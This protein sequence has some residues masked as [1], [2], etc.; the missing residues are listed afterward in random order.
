MQFKKPVLLISIALI[1]S[2]TFLVYANSLNGKFIWDDEYLIEKNTHIRNW[3][4]L[5]KI[6]TEPTGLSADNETHYYRP[7]QILSYLIDYSFWGLNAKGYHFG[8]ILF[9]TLVALAIFWL[10]NI[11]YRDWL[12]ALLTSLSLQRILSKP[13]RSVI[14]LAEL[15]P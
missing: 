15:T 2:L 6:F 14:S 12:L 1:I 5:V 7:V 8:N 13:K 4:G 9:H 3:S 10:I 11:L